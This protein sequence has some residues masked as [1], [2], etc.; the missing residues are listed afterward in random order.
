MSFVPDRLAVS[1]LTFARTR[2]RGSSSQTTLI[3]VS[4]M[5]SCF[6]IS[7]VAKEG[8]VSSVTTRTVCP[9]KLRPASR[10]NLC[11]SLDGSIAE[12]GPAVAL[13]SWTVG[14]PAVTRLGLERVASPASPI[15]ARAQT[16]RK[17]DRVI[18]PFQ[19]LSDALAIAM[20]RRRSADSMSR[21]SYADAPEKA[22][23]RSRGTAHRQLP[24]RLIA[25]YPVRLS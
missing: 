7:R 10:R 6:M 24:T 5:N 25:G 23:Y 14:G 16:C 2:S 4:G 22:N 20:R 13:T 19:S 12:L 11:W 17:L 18:S 8:G 9:E 1:A 21:T 3:P 15:P